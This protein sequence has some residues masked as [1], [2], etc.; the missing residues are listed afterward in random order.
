MRNLSFTFN[1]EEPPHNGVTFHLLPKESSNSGYCIPLKKA[2]TAFHRILNQL[3]QF[4]LV[5]V[6]LTEFNSLLVTFYNL[7]LPYAKS[8]CESAISQFRSFITYSIKEHEFV[9]DPYVV[10]TAYEALIVR[11]LEQLG[12]WHLNNWPSIILYSQKGIMISDFKISS[13]P[14]LQC[15]S[16]AIQKSNN[17]RN[18]MTIN[19]SGNISYEQIPIFTLSDKH[20][21][22]IFKEKGFIDL[23]YIPCQVLPKFTNGFV[24]SMIKVGNDDQKGFTS[25][26]LKKDDQ[27]ITS[28]E[29]DEIKNYWQIS[30]GIVL[31]DI[32][33]IVKVVF[34]KGGDIFTYPVECVIGEKITPKFSLKTRKIDFTKS[35]EDH[36][37]TTIAV[38]AM[39]QKS[40]K[41]KKNL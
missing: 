39:N 19:L 3:N 7:P 15:A 28:K 4:V 26:T 25:N 10:K 17:T 6:I 22:K 23:D 38:V 40:I 16:I 33:S 8:L 9:F 34:K 21:L 2:S 24:I 36:I 13:T 41:E 14:S 12:W 20:Q 1:I 18:I 32:E 37:S 29:I 27:T 35:L 11:V 5:S 31:N 30:H